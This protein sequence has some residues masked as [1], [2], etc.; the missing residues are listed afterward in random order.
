MSVDPTVVLATRCAVFNADLRAA[1]CAVRWVR[2]QPGYENAKVALVSDHVALTT[3]Q[4]RCY[5]NFGG[6]STSYHP[7]QIYDE[8]YSNG[9]GEVFYVEAEDNQADALRDPIASYSL[10]VREATKAFRDRRT[11]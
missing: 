10:V 7:N 1:A 5:S 11:V 2:A 3:G 6:F 8:L 9:G 4:R